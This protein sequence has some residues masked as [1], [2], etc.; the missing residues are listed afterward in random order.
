M[1]DTR[2]ILVEQEQRLLR[3]MRPR[4]EDL[5]EYDGWTVGLAASD[6]KRS[7]SVNALGPS[8]FPLDEKIAWCEQRYA[9]RGL[10]PVFRLTAFSTDG[11]DEALAARGYEVFEPSRVLVRPAGIPLPAMTTGLRFESLP[12]VEWLQWTGS[13]SQR[14]EA[15]QRA[16]AARLELSPLTRHPVV[17]LEGDRRVAYGMAMFDGAHGGLFDIYVSAEA[18]RSGVGT[19][20]CASL[21]EYGARRGASTTW[22]SVLGN[23]TPAHRLYA[24]LGFEFLYEYW[25]RV[26]PEDV[27]A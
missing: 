1:P 27:A 4:P 15:T 17:G 9:E 12:L 22:L 24:K 10:P 18:R 11:L 8:T 26:R 20:L 19:A 23:N 21:I 2:T 25:Y 6:A 5:L 13:I 14:P 7:R 16:I 3:A